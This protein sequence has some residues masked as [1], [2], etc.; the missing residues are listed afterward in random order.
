MRAPVG[1]GLLTSAA[2]TG[3]GSGVTRARSSSLG[4]T[5]APRLRPLT[6]L[7][8]HPG[9]ADGY[10]AERRSTS[11]PSAATRSQ[12]RVTRI[13]SVRSRAGPGLPSSA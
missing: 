11:M 7:P 4:P 1:G 6:G 2:L 8:P 13:L 12:F 10:P 3:N 9:R 5:L